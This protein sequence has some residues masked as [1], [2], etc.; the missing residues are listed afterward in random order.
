MKWVNVLHLYQPANIESN[1]IVEATNLSYERIIRALEDCPQ[2]RITLNIAGSLLKRW[3]EEFSYLDL[4]ERIKKLIR[5]GQVELLGSAAYHALLPLV[6]EREALKQIVE[7]ENVLREHFGEDLQLKG[8]FLPELA[9]SADIARL[10]KSRGYEWILV[11]EIAFSGSFGNVDWSKKYTDTNSGLSV[12]F[13][14]RAYS[15]SYV[16]TT[17]LEILEGGKSE[18]MVVTASDAELYGLRHLDHLFEFENLLC[19]PRLEPVTVSDYL[20]GLS[21]IDEVGVVASSWQSSPLELK[22]NQAFNLWKK[23]TN[24]L[25][26][27]LWELAD[28]AEELCF[29]NSNDDNI[30]WSRW[31]LVRG[32][33]SCVFWWASAHDFSQVYGPIAWSPDEVNKGIDELVR[34]VRSLKGIDVETRLKA[35]KMASS[36][37]LNLW[38]EHWRHHAI[39]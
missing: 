20:G 11:D 14:H 36:I 27:K 18:S 28:F 9:Y 25:H 37:R 29:V 17:L 23:P 30:L 34:A 39:I 4:V 6:P 5:S 19:H 7:Q 24:K 32:L 16:P 10:I 3:V 8:F 38:Q 2:A 12:V 26:K 13:R 35:E 31:H 1:K 22:R 33:A 15:E 21:K